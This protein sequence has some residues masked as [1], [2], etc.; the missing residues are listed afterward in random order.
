MNFIHPE[1]AARL[2]SW[3][4]TMAATAIVALGAWLIGLGGY[5]LVPL[6]G[7]VCALGVIWAAIALRRRRFRRAV[8]APG[9]VEVDEGQVGYLGPTFG[10]FVSLRELTEIRVID[11]HGQRLWRLKQGDGQVLLIPLAAAGAEL[12]HDAFSTLPGIDMAV[13]SRALDAQGG[14][15]ILWRHPAWAALT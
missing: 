5:F 9:V 11:I 2:A 4:E 3:H 6:G 7:A 13:L 8:T 1:L 15:D 12:L 10:G 14:T